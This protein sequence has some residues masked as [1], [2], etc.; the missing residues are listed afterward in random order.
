MQIFQHVIKTHCHS[1]RIIL[2]IRFF[3][4]C[5][6][7]FCF[8]FFFWWMHACVSFKMSTCF[9]WQ[10]LQEMNSLSYF[11]DTVVSFFPDKSTLPS[12]RTSARQTSSA[13]A[14]I[15]KSGGTHS[16]NK[17]QGKFESGAAFPNTLN[18]QVKKY[19]SSRFWG[20][21]WGS[22][23]S[24]HQQWK[25]SEWMKGKMETKGMKKW[26]WCDEWEVREHE[27]WPEKEG[28]TKKDCC[29]NRPKE[30][31]RKRET[32]GNHHSLVQT[33]KEMQRLTNLPVLKP[34]PTEANLCSSRWPLGEKIGVSVCV[35]LSMCEGTWET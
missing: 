7:G 35:C 30:A 13:A 28:I 26:R 6:I 1:W 2:L 27:N 3:F 21:Y 20:C 15:S 33:F 11:G 17:K 32:R 18:E 31:W 22:S 34:Q 23:H 12:S 24:I 16:H 5:L 8:V 25:W 4:P 29:K 9:H 10:C 19:H 14:M